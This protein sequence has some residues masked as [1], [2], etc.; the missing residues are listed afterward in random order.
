MLYP[1]ISDADMNLCTVFRN[2]VQCGTRDWGAPGKDMG[3]EAGKG[4][5][6]RD[7]DTPSLGVN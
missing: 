2:R 6:T 4:P 3:Q 1:Q 7:W 5:G